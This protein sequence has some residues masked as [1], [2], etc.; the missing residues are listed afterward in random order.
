MRKLTDQQRITLI[1]IRD[2]D[3]PFVP[4]RSEDLPKEAHMMLRRLVTRGDLK[5]EETDDGPAFTLTAQ[6]LADAS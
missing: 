3:R 5:V 6:G 4:G 2:M 1:L